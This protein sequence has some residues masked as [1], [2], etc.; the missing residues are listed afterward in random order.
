MGNFNN[1]YNFIEV[2]SN[3]K[4]FNLD[5]NNNNYIKLKNLKKLS[6]WEKYLNKY[7]DKDIKNFNDR[8]NTSA[9]DYTSFV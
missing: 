7:F 4:N 5:N 8:I 2:Y 9:Y 6:K 3:L 1:T